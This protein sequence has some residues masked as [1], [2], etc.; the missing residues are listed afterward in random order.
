MIY[1]LDPHALVNRLEKKFQKKARAH[2]ER[3][4]DQ[5]EFKWLAS[6]NGTRRDEAEEAIFFH[7][8]TQG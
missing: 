3:K 6:L 4:Q 5:K 7:F 1:T 2:K 8:L